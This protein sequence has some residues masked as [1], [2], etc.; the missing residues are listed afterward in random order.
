[1]NAQ[2]YPNLTTNLNRP[3]P[4]LASGLPKLDCFLGG[5][6][7]WGKLVEWGAP[8]GQEGWSLILPFVAQA[9]QQGYCLWVGP[10]DQRQPFPPSWFA[11]GVAPGRMLFLN[12]S[13]PLKEA[14][15]VCPHSLVR[16]ILLDAPKGLRNEDLAYL[17]TQA[18]LTG[19]L[20]LLVR[21]YFLSE[22]RGNVWAALRLNGWRRR[23]TGD[24]VLRCL[25]GP[26][27]AEVRL[28]AGGWP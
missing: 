18:R 14:K 1:M 11:A 19:K 20:I 27:A 8:T 4:R 13:K 24:W 9:S 21:P 6:L 25:K 17:S 15:E 16:L 28:P 12:S 7:P 10:E 2:T 3:Q 5:G 26:L 22:K 23:R